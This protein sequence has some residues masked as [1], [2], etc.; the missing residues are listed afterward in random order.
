MN[1]LAALLLLGALGGGTVA[2]PVQAQTPAPL[3]PAAQTPAPEP[4]KLAE[5]P[6]LDEPDGPPAGSLSLSQIIIQIESRPD[7]AFIR[8]I[9]WQ[10]GRYEI[11]YRTRDGR[12]RVLKIDPRTG[13]P[14][15][16]NSGEGSLPVPRWPQQG[17]L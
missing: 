4:P 9:D 13:R 1:Q 7:M 12:D 16:G 6:N 11:E 15:Y 3:A 14:I 17:S 8:D 5:P 10:D 2:Q